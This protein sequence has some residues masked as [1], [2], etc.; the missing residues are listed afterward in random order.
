M[1][2]RPSLRLARAATVCAL[3]VGLG[4]ASNAWSQSLIQALCD[5]LQ[6]QPRPAGQPR[7]AAPDRRNAGAGRR[8]LAAEG[9]ALAR[10]QQGRAGFDPHP[11]PADVLH[12][13]RPLHDAANGPAAVPRRQDGGRH[14]GRPGQ[15]P[16]AT[17]RSRR[18]RAECPPGGGHLVCRPGAEHRDR[19]R[20][21][22]QRA[23]AHPAARCHPRTLPCR[24]VDDHRRVAGRSAARGRQGRPGAGRSPDPDRRGGL[25]ARDRTEAGQ[26]WR[27]APDR[28]TAHQR[29]R[30][31]L[32]GDGFRAPRRQ[33]PISR[34][35]PPATA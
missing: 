9:D 31:D 25:P 28:R 10:V 35:P 16:G 23:R 21:A 18:H 1:R 7:V 14:Q 22:Q 5:H 13:E 34:S 17:G 2:I 26:A 27:N 33:R 4:A 11:H 32:A 29:G 12:P 6:Q 19:R 15:H 3:A 8:Q 20:A 24:R 30:G